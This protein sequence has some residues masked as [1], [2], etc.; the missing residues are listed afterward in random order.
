MTLTSQQETTLRNLI[1]SHRKINAHAWPDEQFTKYRA[2]L[3]TKARAGT[4]THEDSM[5]LAAFAT[6]VVS[7]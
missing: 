2:L 3:V 6:A 4:L 1:G 5:I 7:P